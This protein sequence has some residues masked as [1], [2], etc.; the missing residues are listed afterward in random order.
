MSLQL[1][2]AAALRH[3]PRGLSAM[4]G[5]RLRLKRR[6]RH[7]QHHRHGDGQGHRNA[8]VRSA[9]ARNRRGR[10]TAPDSTHQRS[11][12]ECDCRRGHR[13]KSAEM[14]THTGSGDSP[15]AIYLSPDGKWLSVAI[16][17]IYQVVVAELYMLKLAVARKFRMRGKNPEHAEFSP[18]GKWLYV[19]AEEADCVDIIDLAK[20]RSAV[21]KGRQAA[22]RNRFP[23]GQQSRLRCRENADR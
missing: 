12:V 3:P 6:K 10:T 23:A 16:E 21:G 22:A 18:D 8:Q 2:G 19:S 11:D 15:E 5:D 17:E 13:K 9:T 1:R 20:A 7:H 14:A 4:G